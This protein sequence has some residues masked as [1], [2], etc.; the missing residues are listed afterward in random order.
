MASYELN[1]DFEASFDIEVVQRSLSRLGYEAD[2]HRLRQALIRRGAFEAIADSAKP[3]GE[4]QPFGKV[5][6]AEAMGELSAQIWYVP[7][8]IFQAVIRLGELSGVG[9]FSDRQAWADG[10]PPDARGRLYVCNHVSNDSVGCWDFSRRC[11][12]SITLPETFDGTVSVCRGGKRFVA[13][14]YNQSG[15]ANATETWIHVLDADDTAL[16]TTEKFKIGG[17][18]YE[19]SSDD[20]GNHLTLGIQESSGERR[21]LR[22]LANGTQR[23]AL[24]LEHGDAHYRTRLSPDRQS[25]VSGPQPLTIKVRAHRRDSSKVVVH[26]AISLPHFYAGAYTWSPCSRFVAFFGRRWG[27]L[28]KS[29]DCLWVLEMGAER[30]YRLAFGNR[31]IPIYWT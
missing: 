30:I 2:F 25:M 5:D 29:E 1:S 11:S 20:D 26:T 8:Q 12:S 14:K 28:V 22:C 9:P 15:V 4:P 23:Q 24:A 18:V 19:L 21:G 27:K 10:V 17:S 3:V 7:A 31:F 16:V 13:R 6:L